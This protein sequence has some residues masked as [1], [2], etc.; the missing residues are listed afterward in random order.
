MEQSLATEHDGG[1]VGAGDF[2]DNLFVQA[3]CVSAVHSIAAVVRCIP[4][5]ERS[6]VSARTDGQRLLSFGESLVGDQISWRHFVTLFLQSSRGRPAE[7]CLAIHSCS[8]V[9]CPIQ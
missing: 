3:I 4:R 2:L 6:T 7:S 5:V 1:R 8:H 9:R